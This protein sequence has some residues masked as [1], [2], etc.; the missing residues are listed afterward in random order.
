MNPDAYIGQQIDLDG[1]PSWQPYQCYD[2][3]NF[4]S[5]KL[6]YRRFVG[7]KASGIYGQQPENYTWVANT[8]DGVPPA[9]VS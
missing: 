1:Y 6:G 5:N 4:W 7:E 9:G 2:W 3:A 8:P